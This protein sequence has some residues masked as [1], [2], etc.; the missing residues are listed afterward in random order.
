[1]HKRNGKPKI[2]VRTIETDDLVRTPKIRR[3]AIVNK[4][5]AFLAFKARIQELFIFKVRVQNG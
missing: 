5:S 4:N 3:F 2:N 1:M